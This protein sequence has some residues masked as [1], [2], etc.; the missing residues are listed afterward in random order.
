MIEA[1]KT[2]KVIKTRNRVEG[3]GMKRDA[4]KQQARHRTMLTVPRELKRQREP[5]HHSF[6]TKHARAN[7]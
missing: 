3:K 6:P 5:I 1:A 4:Q 2:D 7:E